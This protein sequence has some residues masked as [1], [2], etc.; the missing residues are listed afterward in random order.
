MFFLKH[1]I[2]SLNK[3]LESIKS[4][5]TNARLTTSTS[6][7]DITEL[8]NSMNAV[9]DERREA[10]TRVQLRN[11]EFKRAMTNISHDLRTPLT[12]A[13]GYL[14]MAR[15]SG[16]HEHLGLVEERLKSLTTLMNSLFEYT[17]I[18]EGRLEYNPEKV[19]LCDIL[20]DVIAQFYGDFTAKG[21]EVSLDI[22]DEPVYAICDKS[23]A[24]RVVQNLVKN[25]LEHGYKRFEIVLR[26]S[27]IVFRNT[28]RDIDS[29]DVGLMF[30]RFY[31]ADL[32]RTS[33]NTG[34]GLA[35][36]KELVEAMGWKITVVKSG[37]IISCV[38][39]C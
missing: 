14:Q 27:E 34:L 5:D 37:D 24:E 28:V 9:L 29:L 36:V 7:K 33:G 4:T 30:E 18:I 12:S 13:I 22:P 39:S 26:D 31:T 16:S 25:A 2:Q 20:R 10:V 11:T 32:S 3:Q 19:S 8:C 21:F 15:E 38:L 17:K 23:A 6:D 1:D 35:I